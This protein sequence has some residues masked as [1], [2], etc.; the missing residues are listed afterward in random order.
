MPPI[1]SIITLDNEI[2]KQQS[3]ELQSEEANI[4]PMGN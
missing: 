2:S 4:F 3:S 1:G